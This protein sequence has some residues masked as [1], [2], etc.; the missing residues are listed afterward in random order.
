[1]KDQSFRLTGKTN[2]SGQMQ[3]YN[4]HQF[5]DFV[6][7]WPNAHFVIA[8]YVAPS[9]TSQVL[10]HYYNEYIL[11]EFQK[12][13]IKKVGERLTLLG[14]HE[15]LLSLTVS[16]RSNK[17]EEEEH[18]AFFPIDKA[19]NQRVIEYL[20]ELKIIG[21]SVLGVILEDPRSL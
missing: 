4:K 11:P 3:F 21:S 16:L 15:E 12:A 6:K 10:L 20:D 8:V 14:V 19:G 7:Q 2:D 5:D 1:M 18:G 13:F 17:I 9:A